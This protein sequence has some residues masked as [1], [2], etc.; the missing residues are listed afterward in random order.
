MAANAS[1]TPTPSTGAAAPSV[2]PTSGG[3]SGG[4]VKL[5]ALSKKSAGAK[6]FVPSWNKGPAPAGAAAATATAT[7]TS[8]P[9]K[10]PPPP[11]Q[12]TSAGAIAASSA[13]VVDP[14]APAYAMDIECVAIGMGHNDRAVAQIAVVD[15][16]ERV[17]LNC[18]VKPEQKITSYLSALTNL[19]PE[20]LAQ[21]VS[22]T[23]AVAAVRRVLPSNAVLVGQNILKD[24]SWIGLVEGKDFSAMQDLG[25]LWRVWN[26]KYQNFSQFSLGH[27]CKCLLGY[28]QPEPHDAVSDSIV[29]MRLYLLHKKLSAGP[30]SGLAAAQQSLMAV[31][32]EPSFASRNP[33]LDGVCMGYKKTCKCG[34]P[35]L[36]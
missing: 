11:P 25:G 29:S 23:D 3:S 13:V 1:V 31:Q 7:A 5:S 14:N 28:G 8:V 22:L 20:K 10:S 24:I 35:F 34:Q 15:S 30:A 12:S 32:P 6:E 26:A 9:V 16:N 18:Y 27:E 4:S 33:T 21:G 19:S 17:V 36:F 2:S